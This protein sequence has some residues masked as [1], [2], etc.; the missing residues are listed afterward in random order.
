MYPLRIRQLGGGSDTHQL[1]HVHPHVHQPPWLEKPTCLAPVSEK[2]VMLLG[3][4]AV[5]ALSRFVPAIPWHR[6]RGTSS[7][8]TRF[9][10]VKMPILNWL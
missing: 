3:A 2:E 7:S 6:G 8:P 5:N 10:C 4:E 1:S 9:K